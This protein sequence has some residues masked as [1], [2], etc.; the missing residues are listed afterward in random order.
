[1]SSIP[2]ILISVFLALFVSLSFN[3]AFSNAQEVEGTVYVCPQA[4]SMKE[5]NPRCPGKIILKL[6]ETIEGLTL[7][8]T[9]YEDKDYY[10]VLGFINGGGAVNL[11]PI[12]NAGGPY[13]GYGGLPTTF[14]AGSSTDPNNDPLQYRW[15][16]NND[17]TW[18]TDWLA[19]STT[20]HIWNNDYEGVVKLEVGDGEFNSIA[21]ASI[22]IKSPKSFKQDAISE[23]T[24]SK[25]GNK[26]ND[27]KIDLIISFINKSL[28]ND[29]WVDSSHLAFFEKGKCGNFDENLKSED[30]DF[31]KLEKNCPKLGIMVFYYEKAAVELMGLRKEFKETIEKLVKADFLLA[32]VSLSDAQNTSVKNKKFYKIV[33]NQ[34]E[35]SEK[36]LKKA[37]DESKK[38]K[39]DKA[40]SRL[41]KSWLYSQLAIKFASLK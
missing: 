39:P 28:N 8:I 25:T 2:K 26:I 19:T 20:N 18:D 15:D 24:S 36:E 23:L 34:I 33:E 10:M 11:P 22:K 29:L 7:T 4:T 16:F 21:S 6:G 40:I 27:K 17:G 5:V 13:E 31:K 14:D 30:L 1:M 38:N 32:S 12:A 9:T 3:V 37:G 41:A 35:L